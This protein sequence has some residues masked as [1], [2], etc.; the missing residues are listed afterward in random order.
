[1]LLFS[2]KILTTSVALNFFSLS[3][4]LE[5]T[6]QIPGCRNVLVLDGNMKNARQV[7][8]VKDAGELHFSSVKGTI[9]VG[10]YIYYTELCYTNPCNTYIINCHANLTSCLFQ[11]T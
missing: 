1:M 8:I 2:N 6:C 4:S 5:H 11:S 3:L 7:C 10:T 9:V